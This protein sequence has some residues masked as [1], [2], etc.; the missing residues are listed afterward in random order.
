VAGDSLEDARRDGSAARSRCRFG[1]APTASSRARHRW[2]RPGSR[3]RVRLGPGFLVPAGASECRSA[4]RCSGARRRHPCSLRCVLDQRQQP[5][6]LTPLGPCEPRSNSHPA[7]RPAAEFAW[8]H[9][10][11]GW[12]SLSSQLGRQRV[13]SCLL[14]LDQSGRRG[15]GDGEPK[16]PVQGGEHLRR[17]GRSWTVGLASR[18]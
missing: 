3:C 14:V 4:R 11:R 9:S 12:L 5:S 15:S 10:R 6:V 13:S 8:I 18:L 17:R 2:I 16:S 7:R 1:L